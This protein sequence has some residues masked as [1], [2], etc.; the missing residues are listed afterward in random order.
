MMPIRAICITLPECP[1]RTAKARQH[2]KDRSIDV[3]FFDGIHAEKFGLSTVHTYDVDHPGTNFRIGYKCT[4]IWL[5]HYLL[6]TA[7]NRVWEDHWLIMEDDVCLAEDWHPRMIAALNDAPPDFDMLYVGSCCCA[8]KPTTHVK[9]EAFKVEWPFCTHAYIVAKKALPILLR[10]QRKIYA[11]IDV[12]MAFHSF[13]E[14]KVV[15][16]LPTICTQFD[17]ILSP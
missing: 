1:D 16:V 15:T 11:P 10:T 4:G 13:P 6:W 2:F 12:S 8:N 9:G 14:M 5:S 17:T 3:T 7:L